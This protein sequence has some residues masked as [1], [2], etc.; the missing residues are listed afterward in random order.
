MSIKDI[1]PQPQS[2]DLEK[3]TLENTNYRAVAWSAVYCGRRMDLPRQIVGLTGTARTEAAQQARRVGG[4]GDP[5]RV[6]PMR[7]GPG[8]AAARSHV[9]WLNRRV[10][11]DFQGPVRLRGFSAGSKGH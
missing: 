11:R 10:G 8:C 4:F 6:R 7:S 9:G 5:G 2:F 3:A 1:G